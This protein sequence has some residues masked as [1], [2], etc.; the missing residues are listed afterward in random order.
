[1]LGNRV[2]KNLSRDGEKLKCVSVF[3][4]LYGG[5]VSE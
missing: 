5:D 3:Y 4:Q 1:M 2:N